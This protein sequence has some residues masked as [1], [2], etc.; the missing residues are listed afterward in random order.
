MH[1]MV[2]HLL[3]DCLFVCLQ[4][5][6][7]SSVRSTDRWIPNSSSL[8]L[9]PSLF[10]FLLA[11]FG[12]ASYMHGGETKIKTELAVVER[13]IKGHKQEFGIELFARL[14][15]KEDNE[16]WLPTDRQVRNM[17]DTCRGDIQRL[18]NT[19]KLKREEIIALGGSTSSKT[20]A[21]LDGASTDATA[22]A[23]AGG[24]TNANSQ[25]TPPTTTPPTT[26]SHPTSS[27]SFVPPT[28]AFSDNPG[29]GFSSSVPATMGS[30]SQ[31][32]LQMSSSTTTNNNNND[33]PVDLLL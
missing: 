25:F 7:L 27:S 22:G 14:V 9:P 8:S 23:A 4:N 33:G 18:E 11:N 15:E 3:I 1:G 10:L 12:K 31:Q 6:I 2:R 26:Q 29:G 24:D 5:W 16:G 13:K 21:G 20:T 19:K 30:A 32:Q 17:Y 28:S